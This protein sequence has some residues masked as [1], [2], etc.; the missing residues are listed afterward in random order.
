MKYGTRKNS[1][2]PHLNAKVADDKPWQKIGRLL[3]HYHPTTFEQQN[4]LWASLGA[5]YMPSAIFKIRTMSFIDY[6]PKMEAPPIT[7]ITISDH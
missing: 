2:F 4:N 5:K 1:Q 3:V 6:E 7:E